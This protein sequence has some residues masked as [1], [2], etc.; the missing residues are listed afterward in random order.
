MAC[1]LLACSPAAVSAAHAAE[2]IY[3]VNDYRYVPANAA[4]DRDIGHSLCGTRCNALATNFSNIMEPGGW[5]VVKIGSNKEI[6]VELNS[7]FLGGQ[8]ICLV[9]EY[10]VKITDPGGP[11]DQR[12]AAREKANVR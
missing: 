8:C 9:D 4:D 11:R 3:L 5:S 6:T 10:S 12:S 2:T 1:S 7:P